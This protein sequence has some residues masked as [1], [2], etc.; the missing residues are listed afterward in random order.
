M[1]VLRTALGFLVTTGGPL[2]RA[3]AVAA[4]AVTYNYYGHDVDLE[5]VF[6]SPGGVATFVRWRVKLMEQ[7]VGLLD[8]ECGMEHVTQVDG[9]GRR[10]AVGTGSPMMGRDGRERNGT[11]WAL[12]SQRCGQSEGPGQVVDCAA[13][14][15][16]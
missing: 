4:R 3:R 1:C 11:P 13:T 6:G 5:S 16:A 7:A 12:P 2:A 14:A 15:S 10:Q 9:L 8:F